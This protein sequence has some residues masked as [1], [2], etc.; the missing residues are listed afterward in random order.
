V[1]VGAAGVSLAFNRA[2]NSWSDPVP[3][4]TFPRIAEVASV[5]ALDLLGNG[6]GCLVWSSPLPG[7]AGTALRYID[8]MGGQKPHL[9]ISV[10]N[11]LGAETHVRYAPSTRFYLRDRQ[12]GRPWITRL[13]FPVQVVERVDTYDWISRNRFVTRYAYHHGYFDGVE[14]EFRGFGMVEQRDTEEF[15]ALSGSDEFPAATNVDAGS[16]VPPVVTKTW[17]HT[18]AFIEGGRISRL[19]E[20]DY[21]REPGLSDDEFR[22]MLL[23]DTVL[24]AGL[25]PEESR[26]G[27]RALKA[28]ILRQEVYAE[29]AGP[30]AGAD[31]IL[32]ANTPFTVTEHSLDVRSVQPTSGNRHAVFFTHGREAITYHYE[33]IAADPRIQHTLTLEVDAYGN[34]L[35]E[36][37][38]AY[39]RRLT[40][41]LVAADGQ[42]TQ[43]PNPGLAGFHVNDEAKQITSLVTYTENGVTNSVDAA[44]SLRNPLPCEALTFE[45]T[46]YPRTGLASRFQAP[47][48]VEPD[49]TSS[50]R[51]RHKFVDEVPY[52]VPATSNPCR[53]PIEWVRTLYRRDDL[54]DLLP[55]GELE[56]LA[57]R[58]ESYKLAF[59]PGLLAQ[60]FQRPRPGQPPEDLLPDPAAVLGG[61]A[62]DRGGYVPTEALVAGGEFPTN[63]APD[64]WWIPS[65]RSFFTSNPGDPAATESAQMRDHFVVPLRYRDPFGQDA[66]VRFDL[67][68]L[69]MIEA[70]D[71]LGNRV[72][73]DANDYRVL[74]PTL[75]SDQNRNQTEVVYDSLGLSVGTAV[76]GKP[77][78]AI[79]E[80]DTLSGFA[81][82]LTQAELGTLFD[83]PDPRD[84]ARL[85]LQGATTRF[86]YDLDRF[87]RTRQA[88]PG[89]PPQWQP[90]CVATL[91]RETHTGAI[92][93][94]HGL[95]IQISF[96]YAD[97]FGRLIQKKMGA[98]PGPLLDSGPVTNP[99]WVGSGWTIFNNKG[100]PV[101]QYET[102]FSSTHRF[103]FGLIAG[104]SPVLFYDP[105]ERVVTRLFPNQTFEK[106]V[107]D[108]W[109]QS[110]Y[111][112][113][114]T[115]A[116]RNAQTGDPQTDPDIAGY[117]G[118]YF[119]SLPASPPAPARL[120]WH[121]RRI[122]G[123]LGPNERAAAARAAAHADTPTTVQFDALGRPFLTVAQNRVVCADHD[124]DGTSGSF[125]TRVDLDIEGNQR[126]SRDALEQGGDPLG[127][128]VMRY[129]YDIVGN[130]IHQLSMDAGARWILHDVAGKQSRA[131]D[132]RGHNFVTV[133]D[134][135][136]RPVEE[137]VRGT[138]PD[139]DPRTLNSTLVVDRIEYGEGLADAES[140][141]LRTRV[142]RQFDSAGVATNARLNA[143]GDPLQA[144]D[145]KGNVLCKTRRLSSDYA[146]IPDW[147]LNPPLDAE[148]FEDSTLYDALNRPI[149]SIAPHS[150]LAG[151]KR[152]VLQPVFNEANLLERVDVWL[153]RG[154][155]PTTLLDPTVE[156]T[157]SVGVTNIDYDAKGQRLLISFKNGASTRYRY[158]P[159]TFRLVH[160]YARRGKLFTEDCDNPQPPPALIASPETPPQS[161]ACGLQSL[162]YTYDPAGNITHILDDAQQTIYFRNKR[163]EPSNEYTYDAI[164]RLVQATGREHLGQ[165][166]GGVDSPTAPDAHNAFHTRLAHPGDGQTMGTYTE[167]FVYDAV[168]N[169]LQMQHRGSDPANLG[170]TRAYTY[171]EPSVVED[172][173]GGAPQ[174]T[175]NRLSATILNP[176]AANPVPEPYQHDSH[177]NV[178][179]MPHLGGG[180]SPNMSLDYRDLIRHVDLGGG[181]V[182]YYSYDALGERIRKVWEKAPGLTEERIYLGGSEIFR[183][184]AGAIGAGS[185]SLERETLH[186]VDGQQRIALV[187]TRTLDEAGDDPAP[188][189]LIRYQ[190]G[191]HLAS[192]SLELDED[193]LVISYEE[194]AP[195]GSST[196]QAVRSQTPSAKR[197]RFTGKERDEE[198]GL[199]Y[200]GARY[201]A[202]W[203]GRWTSRDPSDNER[204]RG[205]SNPYEYCRGCPIV[206]LDPDGR[207][208]QVLKES[209]ISAADLVNK[210]KYDKSIPQQIRDSISV[211]P[212][213]PSSIQFREGLKGGKMS[214]ADAAVW[215]DWTKLYSEAEV[216]ARGKNF[217]FTSG[218]LRILPG[219]KAKPTT[220]AT[221]DVP[222]ESIGV[223]TAKDFTGLRTNM[224][225]VSE[226][227]KG[228]AGIVIP[229]LHQKEQL[230]L[231]KRDTGGKSVRDDLADKRGLIVVVD[232]IVTADKV[233]LPMNDR[234]IVHTFFHELALH[235]SGIA[236]EGVGIG[237]GSQRVDDLKQLVD[238]LLPTSGLAADAAEV[239][240]D[241]KPPADPKPQPRKKAPRP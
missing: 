110:S 237:H 204:Q 178:V 37:A 10:E 139:S 239:P 68:D 117:V 218:E 221:A 130:R 174:K 106:V 122:G 55:L 72:T 216:A 22:A 74:Q 170:W 107:F 207:D 75:V 194:Y 142:Y 190:F 214:K 231:E 168:G 182:A 63:D 25:S 67:H 42:V 135:L 104:V 113:N 191:N 229:S 143:S 203:L 219:D 217:A 115:C 98:E 199:Y 80:G 9:L 28:S 202:A 129:A 127:R 47:D 24:P 105:A 141:N 40:V 4:A 181:G 189:R 197:Y 200:Q 93:P 176:N 147:A 148:T 198:T 120:T 48:L 196:Y 162:H 6:T 175:S 53:R 210:I 23:A 169:I 83:A 57:L 19:Y 160:A 163:V 36:A 209:K 151:A 1:Y 150:S 51:L 78:P 114:D 59:T 46:G 88:N 201:Y 102:F 149:Q 85:L 225:D 154:G 235:A 215:K 65:G 79:V 45:L 69:L 111:D 223:G 205:F 220:L 100:K 32:R 49:P 101:R 50:G 52:E 82:N 185:A 90:P 87:R 11:N 21:F 60:V 61:Q 119:A 156:P 66:F 20:D 77:L 7:S 144:F 195:Y 179:R 137:R 192:V 95:R 132:S 159:E 241:A 136:R 94:P 171:A 206:V 213:N 103:E 118:R 224:I 29:D 146:A 15:A 35:K 54:R 238:K 155:E 131:W 81:A 166:N 167:R 222:S 92:L 71:A 62:G 86:V 13:P 227:D 33:R 108:P 164:Y 96:S 184:H 173:S 165:T 240:V 14:R 236:Q 43:V 126:A 30:G 161:G 145:F 26:E 73:V 64:H 112:A 211:D 158:D 5:A 116:A 134:V 8:L 76:M 16:H 140:L 18:G 208:I 124:L 99:R 3:L 38:I 228:T 44:E 180:A 233:S 56:S 123:A 186:V 172:G 58:G 125:H 109:Q 97:G 138:T 70:E 133:Y 153:E 121:A 12:A 232:R 2:G 226:P 157:S 212:K 152:N 188:A 187:E 234:E 193:A 41:R 177:G 128:V 183:R 34:V 91:A 39:G 17:F 230:K 89:D 27:C 31:E 84:G